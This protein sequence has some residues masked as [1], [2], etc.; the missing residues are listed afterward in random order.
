[1][2]TPRPML[3]DAL[4]RDALSRRAAGPHSTA[5][6]VDDVLLVVQS[7]TQN[8]G[9]AIHLPRP[10]RPLAVLVVGALLVSALVGSALMA[11]ARLATPTIP[12]GDGDIAFVQARYAWDGN[13]DAHG[14]STPTVEGQGI[15][16]VPSAGGEPTFVAGVPAADRQTLVGYSTVGPAV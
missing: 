6:L 16:R 8:R 13:K 11:G 12:L 7:T 3:T 4:L 9:W 1:M 10:S 2:R 14:A 15:F 5:E